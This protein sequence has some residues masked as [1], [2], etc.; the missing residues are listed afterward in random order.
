MRPNEDMVYST[1]NGP[2]WGQTATGLGWLVSSPP[3]A[4]KTHLSRPRPQIDH[5]GWRAPRTAP[6]SR[7]ARTCVHVSHCMPLSVGEAVLLLRVHVV[8]AEAPQ[9]REQ[10][11]LTAVGDDLCDEAAEEKP[12][13]SILGDD[14]R[15]GRHVG[16]RHG[17]C[18]P[19]DTHG[20]GRRPARPTGAG[21]RVRAWGRC[22]A[23]RS[24]GS[25]PVQ[26]RRHL[27][28][29]LDHTDRIGTCVGDG[30]AAEA[31]GARRGQAE[32]RQ[33]RG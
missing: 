32:I 4:R 31:C 2:R 19:G 16:D 5:L 13:D 6:K 28:G 9:D 3:T 7:R 29:G 25:R 17:R 24:A 10:D 27:L 15:H 26:L 23:V 1:R 22:H 8:L 20:D 11:A 33:R 12:R 21:M 18:L 30:A 14:R